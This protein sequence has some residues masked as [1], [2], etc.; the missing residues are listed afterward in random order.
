VQPRCNDPPSAC[1]S[2]PSQSSWLLSHSK[3]R[4]HRGK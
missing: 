3:F 2:S 4:V 1:S